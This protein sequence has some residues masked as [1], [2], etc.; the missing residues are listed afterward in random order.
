MS[1]KGR[2]SAENRCRAVPGQ[3]PSPHGAAAYQCL[4]TERNPQKQQT[5]LRKG[6][7]WG[8]KASLMGS[9]WDGGHPVQTP[10]VLEKSADF[11]ETWGLMHTNSDYRGGL[12][13]LV[14]AFQQS[15]VAQLQDE[16]KMPFVTYLVC[17]FEGK[18]LLNPRYSGRFYC[19]YYTITG[20]QRRLSSHS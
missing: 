4:E 14:S 5:C 6:H 18:R 19:L 7:A 11:K 17:G 16:N 12:S 2:G 8:S 1:T 20:H 15:S 9:S 13:S 10:S 3:L